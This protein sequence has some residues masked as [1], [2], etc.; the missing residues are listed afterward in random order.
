MEH[1]EVGKGEILVVGLGS[2]NYSWPLIVKWSTRSTLRADYGLARCTIFHCGQSAGRRGYDHAYFSHML[3]ACM[4]AIAIIA[5]VLIQCS[6]RSH[7][8]YDCACTSSVQTV[9]ITMHVYS[10]THWLSLIKQPAKYTLYENWKV[11]FHSLGYLNCMQ[12]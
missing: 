7:H 4:H 9:Y 2:R 5:L 8:S 10:S 3:C 1:S 12:K 11:V 6:T